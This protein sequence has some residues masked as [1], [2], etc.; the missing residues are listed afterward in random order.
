MGF[1]YSFIATRIFL[2]PICVHLIIYGFR[3]L[4]YS[5]HIHFQLLD[6][7]AE[8]VS[9][10]VSLQQG[11]NKKWWVLAKFKHLKVAKCYSEIVCIP[12]FMCFQ[13][14]AMM[15]TSIQSTFISEERV[16]ATVIFPKSW[17]F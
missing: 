17:G 3:G 12:S 16:S 10:F 5:R 15:P 2:N 4:G 14:Q 11:N 7:D 13:C 8:S 1:A 9:P 6:S